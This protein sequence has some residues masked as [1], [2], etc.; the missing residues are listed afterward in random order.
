MENSHAGLGRLV[1]PKDPRDHL[2]PKKLTQLAA[3]RTFRHWPGAPEVLDQ[4]GTSQ[5]VAYSTKQFLMAS[6]IR[7]GANLVEEQIYDWCQNNDEWLGNAYDGT[8]V[9]AA[10]KWLKANGF[11]AS[12]EWAT[13]VEQLYA[14][15]LLRG[16]AIVG[17]DWTVDMFTPDRWDFIRPTGESMGGHAWLIRGA[18][19]RK[20]HPLRRTV[21]AFRMRNS[22]GRGWSDTGEAW[23][24]AADMAKLIENHGEIA[25]PVEIKRG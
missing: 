2:V 16:P 15:V 8:S 3:E 11:I 20:K 4:G 22:W 25:L 21:G 1:A 13:N 5:C 10:M 18:N 24:S 6:P 12:Y 23:V 14:H 9:R 17:T 19:R 7:Q